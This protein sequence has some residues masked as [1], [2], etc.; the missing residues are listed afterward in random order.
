MRKLFYFAIFSFLLFIPTTQAQDS[1]DEWAKKVLVKSRYLLPER[2]Y[3]QFDNSSYYL[4]ETLWFKAYV[5]SGN[6]DYPTRISNVLYVELVSP[7]G[8]VVETKKYKIDSDGS[9]NGEFELHPRLLSGLYEIRAYTR[10]MTNWGEEAIFSRVF[11]VFDKVNAN[12]WDFKNILDRRRGAISSNN[13]SDEK[14]EGADLKF[15]PEGGNLVAGINSRVAF[16]LRGAEGSFADDTISIYENNRLVVKTAPSHNGKGV[17][18][19][20]PKSGVKYNAEVF[21][22]DKNR[23]KKKYSFSF[24]KINVNGATIGITQD[25]T[26]V[27]VVIKN[28]LPYESQLGFAVMYRGS[29]GYYK[30]YI[31]SERE[32]LFEIPKETLPEGVCKAVLFVCDT[33]PLAERQFFVQHNELQ[34]ND[35]Q[36]VKLRVKANNYHIQNYSPQPNEKIKIEIERE[37][38][39]PIENN[40]EFVLSVRDAAGNQTTSWNY[41]MYS[42]LL[43][44]SDLK[45]YIPDA[46]QYFD[47]ENKRRESQLD[48]LM[49]THGWTSYDWDKLVTVDVPSLQTN[50][51][52]LIITGTLYR[53]TENRKFNIVQSHNLKRMTN[54][55]VRLDVSQDDNTVGMS[56]F[57]TDSLGKFTL[58]IDEFYGK[59]IVSLTAEGSLRRVEGLNYVFAL[60]RYFSPK[61]RPYHFWEKRMGSSIQRTIKSATMDGGITKLNPFEY[62][63]QELDVVSEKEKGQFLRPPMSELRLDY[64]D[65]W[66]YAQDITYLEKSRYSNLYKDSLQKVLALETQ[67]NSS[68]F[69]EN[70]T[71]RDRMKEYR[72]SLTAEDIMHSAARRHKLNWSFWT[73]FVV[74]E[75]DYDGGSLP[76]IDKEYLHGKDPVKMTNFKEI[77][78]RSDK[79]A[80]ELIE[81]SGE[82]FWESK[83]ASLANKHPYTM[84]YGGFLTRH[85]TIPSAEESAKGGSFGSF[86]QLH[87]SYKTGNVEKSMRNPNYLACFVPY[88]KINEESP[89]IPELQGESES[90]RYTMLQGYTKSKEFY[91][92]DYS[93]D[94]PSQS[95]YRRTLLWSPRIT[96]ENGKI[97]VELYNSSECNSVDVSVLGRYGNIYYS[98]DEYIE[99]R[100]CDTLVNIVKREEEIDPDRKIMEFKPDSA[101]LAVLDYHYN[102]GVIY[103]NKGN[104]RNALVA[105]AELTQYNYP[106]AFYSVAQCYLKGHGLARNDS[107]AEDFMKKS[108]QRGCREAQYEYAI[109]CKDAI[110][111]NRD[112]E[113]YSYW[114]QIAAEAEEPRA[115]VEIGDNYLRGNMVE[116]DS[117]KALHCYRLSAEQENALGMYRYAIAMESNSQYSADKSE[118]LSYMGKAAQQG[119]HDAMI[120]MMNYEHNQ[121]N[122][123]AAYSWARK[124][125]LEEN[126]VGTTYVADCYLEGRAVGRDK[127]LAKDLYRQA[128]YAGNREAAEKLRNMK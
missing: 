35:R 120:Y 107:L 40:A 21:A 36:T 1:V 118:I 123:K 69:S 84:F 55:Q 88:D 83:S 33:I 37:D 79:P 126:H 49:L 29:M 113:L 110:G 80:L 20:T 50:E 25:S 112:K 14:K 85:S 5:T 28:N 16:E 104:Y 58:E 98:N 72:N 103:Y 39:N 92:P 53:R 54:T 27:S 122:Y 111:R 89:I 30:K 32:Q 52:G 87:N 31:S 109:M 108:A 65:E 3:L 124:L 44:G 26:N 17:F 125:S 90:R 91:S 73:Q 97:L 57:R 22:A 114:L 66:E 94:T 127:R 38:G 6:Y 75:G 15:Y 46:S 60:N 76:K 115:L 23:K 82:G 96:V 119:L 106:P 48:L 34:K 102:T 64:L 81:N 128:A 61:S 93:K 47:R 56:V 105:F 7:E 70:I 2:V 62:L 101:T 71:E 18:E 100:Y 117:V 95:D 51:K 74:L 43:L 59:K 12:N 24:P 13:L 67:L 11:P 4:G 42:Y 77:I 63:L 41:N 8:Y 19:I 45:G 78:I 10:Y 68:D 99:T 121:Q 86:E 116:K 9:C